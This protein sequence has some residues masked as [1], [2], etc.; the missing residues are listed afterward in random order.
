MEWDVV[1][2]ESRGAAI[3]STRGVFNVIDHARMVADIVSR[4][5][6][7]PGHPVLFDH[8]ELDFGTVGF[9]KMSAARDTHLA[10]DAR[11]GAARTAILMKS[12]ADFGSGRQF[13]LLVNGAASAEVRVFVDEKAAWGWLTG[14]PDTV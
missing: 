13:Q 1:F 7:Y 8:R 10:H 12:V 2:D 14:D 9:A 11:I 4:A 5:Q 3:V 6:W